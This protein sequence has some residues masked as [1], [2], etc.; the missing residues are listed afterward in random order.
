MYQGEKTAEFCD[1]WGLMLESKKKRSYNPVGA[2]VSC[3]ERLSESE[4]ASCQKKY[5]VLL[6][7]MG[8][9]TRRCKG[10]CMQ[11]QEVKRHCCPQD[12]PSLV[13]RQQQ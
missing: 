3:G 13:P 9:T 5:F 2:A 4:A 8:Y 11:L 7:I 10:V 1:R 6:P 12:S